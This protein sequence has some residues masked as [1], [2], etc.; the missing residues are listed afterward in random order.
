MTALTP[1]LA[2]AAAC[3][4][5]PAHQRADV[6]NNMFVRAVLYGDGGSAPVRIRNMSRSGALIES[7]D[8]PTEGLN[9][10]LSRGSLSVRGH[11]AWRRD[12]RAGIRFDTT[13][14][15]S[16]WLPRGSKPTGQQ[17]VDEMVHACRTSGRDGVEGPAAPI[18]ANQ[19]EAIRQLLDCRDTLNAVAEELAGD[20]AIA[21]GHPAALQTIDVTA[22]MLEKLASRLAG[23]A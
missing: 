16:D 1:L 11:I 21:V 6:R 5:D 8:I 3:D 20:T 23:S 4:P 17:R 18:T 2:H 7:S 19:A 22:Q 12:N 14:E 13:I 15:V 9:V 10:R